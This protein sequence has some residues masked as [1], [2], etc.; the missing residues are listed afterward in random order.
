[1]LRCNIARG[2]GP[3]LHKFRSRGYGAAHG[4]VDQRGV[5]MIRVLLPVAVIAA[6]LFA[7]I[8]NDTV[9]GSDLGGGV[10]SLSGHDYVGN[11]I[12]CWMKGEFSVS[13]DCEPKGDTK[14]LAIFGA[15]FVSAVAAV[16]GVIG[17]LPVVGRITSAITM[18]AGVVVIASIGYYVMTQMG[19]DEGLE[20]V[21]WG[22]YLAGG[23]GLL[24]LV[25]GLSGMRGR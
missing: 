6:L 13:G 17:L 8:F 11:T 3:P 24:T 23:G 9:D 10:V 4:V 15:V 5:G 2:A 7:P 22:S 21:Q 1:M 19:S 18:L 16:L 20:G 12:S 14:G 25:S